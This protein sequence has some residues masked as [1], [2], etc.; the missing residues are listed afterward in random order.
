[1]TVTFS[2]DKALGRPTGSWRAHPVEAYE[3]HHGVAQVHS[4][5]RAEP[6]LDG[7]RTGQVWGTMWHGAWENDG[8]RRA[9]LAEI[10]RTVG[11][12]WRPAD[13]TP[14]YAARREAM[15]ETLADAVEQHLDLPM[16]FGRTRIAGR[17]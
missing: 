6:F 4:D 9:W 8:F 5:G 14:A 17:L 11:S 2:A 1:M 7:C 15:L 12:P 13:D 3:I 16:I 10:A